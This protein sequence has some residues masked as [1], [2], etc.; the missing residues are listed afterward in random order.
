MKSMNDNCL[1]D[2]CL[3]N[4]KVFRRGLQQH[5]LETLSISVKWNSSQSAWKL[6]SLAIRNRHVISCTVI[7]WTFCVSLMG[8]A[9]PM[10]NHLH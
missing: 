4:N 8:T 3:S 6:I 7:R 1:F 9:S 2:Q 10:S 5:T